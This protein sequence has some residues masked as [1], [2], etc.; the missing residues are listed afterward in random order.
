MSSR[1]KANII[2]LSKDGQPYVILDGNHAV[3]PIYV[4]PM[5]T[6]TTTHLPVLLSR[7]RRRAG[8]RLVDPQTASSTV[9]HSVMIEAVVVVARRE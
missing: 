5:V 2:I 1:N 6:I 3:A 7:R 4:L 9:I 8:R